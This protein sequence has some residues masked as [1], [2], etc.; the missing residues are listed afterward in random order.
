M[1]QRKWDK[2]LAE[3]DDGGPLGIVARRVGCYKDTV[4]YW[5]KR[6]EDGVTEDGP[7]CTRCGFFGDEKRPIMESGRDL[8]CELTAQ[9]FDLVG[10]GRAGV[11][12]AMMQEGI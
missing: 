3:Q 4:K 2:I 7:R 5:R 8:W 11:L 10:V 6:R 9:G 12:T 1:G